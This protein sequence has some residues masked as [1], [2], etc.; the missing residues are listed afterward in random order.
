MSAADMSTSGAGGTIAA[1]NSNAASATAAVP[2]GVLKVKI[3]GK[4]TTQLSVEAYICSLLLPTPS[5]KGLWV[6][7]QLLQFPSHST[8][9][10]LIKAWQLQLA[11][12]GGRRSSRTVDLADPGCTHV[13]CSTN[14]IQLYGGAS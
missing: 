10:P 1:S 12:A 6:V 9:C 13:A 14:R 3:K 8:I 4:Y 7:S 5:C 2:E 11:A